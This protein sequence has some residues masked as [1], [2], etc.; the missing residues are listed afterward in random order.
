MFVD[1]NALKNQTYTYVVT[2]VD[3]LHNESAVSRTLTVKAS[4]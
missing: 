4:H 3:R 1:P 2:S